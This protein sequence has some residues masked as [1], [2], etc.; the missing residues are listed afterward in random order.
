MVELRHDKANTGVFSTAS[1][2]AKSSTTLTIG[3]VF[4]F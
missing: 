3:Q 4:S 2:T 1:G